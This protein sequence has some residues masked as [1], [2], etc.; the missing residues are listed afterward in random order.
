M[1]KD[2][3]RTEPESQGDPR[4]AEGPTEYALPLQRAYYY[5][6][7]AVDTEAPRH[8]VDAGDEV[9]GIGSRK[10]DKQADEVSLPRQGFAAVL[11]I[12]GRPVI[13]KG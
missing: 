5:Y 6:R 13:R 4:V 7:D 2:A 10:Y 12:P 9:L 8:E 1:G 3:E 11:F